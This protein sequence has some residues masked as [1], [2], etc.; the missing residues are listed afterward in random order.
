MMLE[1]VDQTWKMG[2]A[3]GIF[4]CRSS[5][6]GR[7]CPELFPICLLLCFWCSLQGICA[8]GLAERES[9][10]LNVGTNMEFSSH[11]GGTPSRSGWTAT[12]LRIKCVIFPSGQYSACTTQPHTV[13]GAF[14][15]CA[16]LSLDQ[17]NCT[18]CKASLTGGTCLISNLR[19]VSSST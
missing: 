15:P 16:L 19:F 11:F 5:H 8:H 6:V 7:G 17:H 13:L 14:V 3:L 4:D 12:T 10:R 18:C 1:P 2:V 9:D